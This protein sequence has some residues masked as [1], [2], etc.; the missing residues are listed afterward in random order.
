MQPNSS[1]AAISCW[2]TDKRSSA[3]ITGR[4]TRYALV[5]SVGDPSG[6]L[7][8]VFEFFDGLSL[9]HLQ[10][11]LIAF[12]LKASMLAFCKVF[13]NDWWLSSKR[14]IDAYTLV[15]WCHQFLEKFAHK[16]LS[17]LSEEHTRSKSGG[18]SFSSLR[19]AKMK[20]VLLERI[21][22]SASP[23]PRVRSTTELQQPTKNPV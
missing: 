4:Q 1:P 6:S 15:S 18:P 16:L 12:V 19:I 5:K 11:N 8:F 2:T 14:I 10:A 23:L 17:I 13:D 7:L 9:S 22:L 21:E 3:R 20:M